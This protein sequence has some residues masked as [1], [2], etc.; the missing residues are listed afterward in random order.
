MNTSVTVG[1]PESS[2]AEPGGQAGGAPLHRR[3]AGSPA[4]RVTGRRVLIAIPVLWGVTLLTFVVLN[5]LPGDAATA[6]LGANATPAEVRALSIKLHLN[7]PFWVRYGNWLGGALHGNLGTSLYSHLPVTSILAQRLPVTIELVV[8]ALIITFVVSIPLAI[9]SARRPRGVADRTSMV[10][11]MGG[12][13]VAPYVLALLLILVF[14]DDLQILP[15]LGYQSIGAG[16]GGNIKDLTLAAVT[17]AVPLTAFYTRFLRADLLEQMQSEDYTV[18]ALAKG[19]SRWQVLTR[20]ALRN[21]F[22]GLLTV[23]GLNLATL[24]G[25][26]V[27]V[28]EIFGL[29]GIGYQ[30]LQAIDNRDVPLVEG[31][32]LVFAVVVVLVNLATDLLYGV[33]DPRIRHGRSR[34]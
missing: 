21:S 31:I 17:L 25:T 20:H 7:E 5:S 4:L 15:A 32:V 33:L 12:L 27:I 1:Q 30:L 9:L 11:S 34:S 10:L 28:E 26:T 13:S 2:S 23:I 8:Y 18:T 3:L 14:A 19:L 24:I 22:I 16:I 6:L 29:P